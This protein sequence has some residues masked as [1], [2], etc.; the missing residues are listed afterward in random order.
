MSQAPSAK[1]CLADG[2]RPPTPPGVRKCV[3]LSALCLYSSSHQGLTLTRSPGTSLPHP[4]SRPATGE[5]PTWRLAP[6]A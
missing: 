4:A 1:A 2:E 6:A 3:A 5:P